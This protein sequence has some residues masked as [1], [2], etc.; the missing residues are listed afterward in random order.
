VIDPVQRA[1]GWISHQHWLVRSGVLLAVGAVAGLGQV[2]VSLP[3]FTLIA[4]FVMFGLMRA[5]ASARAGF[6]MGWLFA[7]G[8]FLATLFWIMDPFLVEADRLGWLGPFAVLAMAGGLAL[9]W[10]A[11]FW[12][13]AKLATTAKSRLVS[14]VMF[15][16]LAGL[17]RAYVLT[18]FPWVLPA[19]IWGGSPIAQLTAFVGP[20]GLGLITFTLVALPFLTHRFWLGMAVSLISLAA[21][22]QFGTHRLAAPVANRSDPVYLRLVQPNAPQREKWDPEMI[23]VFF[24]RQLDL[25]HATAAHRPDLVIWPET[26]VPFWL[27]SE[28]D[29]QAAIAAAAGAKTKVII[30]ARRVQGQRFFNSMALLGPD[31]MAAEVY[32]K[33]HLVPFGEYFPLGSIFARFGIY[34]LAAEEGGGFTAGSHRALMD[35]GALGKIRPLICYESVFAQEVAVP[36]ARADWILQI[37][38]DAWFGRLAGPQQ[39]LAQA[40]FRA[41][42]QGLPLVRVANTGISA[43]IDAKGRVVAHLPLGVAGKLDAL[44]PARLPQTIYTQFGDVPVL[45]IVL[46]GLAI[47]GFWRFKNYY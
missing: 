17:A 28:P 35:L 36:N 41:I 15:L 2:P 19:Y 9:F 20:H 23:P 11:A 31:G 32:D 37:T 30:G 22:W 27:D 25:T 10:G 42:E 12:A 33:I 13:S 18:G 8:Y 38:N 46:I 29:M 16:T 6:R 14:L 45:I 44:L 5:T 40:R 47:L 26:S 21:I 4:L 1:H 43:V 7:T 34:G 24:Q 39:H 3:V